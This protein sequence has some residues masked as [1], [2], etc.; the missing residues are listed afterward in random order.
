MYGP[1]LRTL[2]SVDG[3]QHL[4]VHSERKSEY[5]LSSK[6]LIK[7][8]L[9]GAEGWGVGWG[10]AQNSLSFPYHHSTPTPLKVCKGS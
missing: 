5:K 7:G 3:N 10:G 4:Q 9:Q 2:A 8:G 1:H 6:L